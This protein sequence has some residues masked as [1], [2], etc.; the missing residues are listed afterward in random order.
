[1]DN[2]EPIRERVVAEAAA[3][4]ID[5][6]LP[7]RSDIRELGTAYI[8]AAKAERKLRAEAAIAK[9]KAREKLREVIGRKIRI[10]GTRM[11]ALAFILSCLL[12]GTAA[13][14]GQGIAVGTEG[15]T[16][17]GFV[18][19]TGSERW[20]TASLAP[21]GWRMAVLLQSGPEELLVAFEPPG[22]S[23]AQ[24]LDVRINARTGVLIASTS[25]AD[26]PVPRRWELAGQWAVGSTDETVCKSG[27]Q[28]AP[29]SR[30]AALRVDG[31]TI[32]LSP[33]V[34]G[35]VTG[36]WRLLSALGP[37]VFVAVAHVNA[38]PNPLGPGWLLLAGPTGIESWSSPLRDD[39]PVSA[40]LPALFAEPVLGPHGSA[41][42]IGGAWGWKAV[43]VDAGL[44]PP[45]WQDASPVIGSSVPVVATARGINATYVLRALPGAALTRIG[46]GALIEDWTTPPAPIAPAD[47][48]A[49]IVTAKYAWMAARFD[50][51][52]PVSSVFA[53]DP[54]TGA[55]M[56]S[57]AVSS[58]PLH[59]CAVVGQ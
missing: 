41:L 49:V 19:S 5:A 11:R 32:I 30:A 57:L 58:T 3:R 12:A 50:G 43:T 38:E 52:G 45:T 33:P 23:T 36:A 17:V 24:W 15:R 6:A 2:S 37:S 27:G 25:R 14:R 13:A 28:C 20:A 31:S 54:G 18:E 42:L 1:M 47:G 51:S 26:G 16:V 39:L 10:R 7:S 8:M 40:H 29:S 53:F 34:F 55:S 21:D 9:A 35:S 22:E 46:D 44:E 59:L 4:G 56:R 48:R